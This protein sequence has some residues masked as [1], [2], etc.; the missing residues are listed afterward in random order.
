MKLCRL[1]L[2]FETW[3]ILAVRAKL[4][5]TSNMYTKKARFSSRMIEGRSKSCGICVTREPVVT[6]DVKTSMHIVIFIT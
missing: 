5:R 4:V 6:Q 2:K 1:P 3:T